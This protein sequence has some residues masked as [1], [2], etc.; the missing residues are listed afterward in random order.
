MKLFII[1]PSLNSQYLSYNLEMMIAAQNTFLL[2]ILMIFTQVSQSETV[3]KGRPGYYARLFDI[4]SLCPHLSFAQPWS[5]LH[6]NNSTVLTLLQVSY[7]NRNLIHRNILK[8]ENVQ[9]L[10]SNFEIHQESK[11]GE[12]TT[13]GDKK[14]KS[15]CSNYHCGPVEV[16]YHEVKI[17]I[18]ENKV[19]IEILKIFSY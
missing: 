3:F 14:N 15:K 7:R 16:I 5:Q 8:A 1:L 4:S 17:I 9:V 12:N 13:I 19:N 11:S 10:L 2:I 18:G 6:H